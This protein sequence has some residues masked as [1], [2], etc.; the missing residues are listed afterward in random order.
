MEFSSPLAA[1]Q[2]PP[3]PFGFGRDITNVPRPRHNPFG[4]PNFNFRDLSMKKHSSDYFTLKTGVRGSSPTASLAADLSQNFHIDQSPQLP[5]PRRSLFT[6]GLFTAE[7]NREGATTPPIKPSWEGVTTPPI[8]SSSPGYAGDSMDISPLPHK[9][10]FSFIQDIQVQSPTPEPSPDED[11]ISSCE[12]TA[13]NFLQ[14]PPVRPLE[15]KRSA[16]LRPAFARSRPASTTNVPNN[17]PQE[18][19]PPF[20]FGAGGNGLTTSISTSSLD[21]CFKA[22]PPQE[23]NPFDSSIDCPP[24]PRHLFAGASILARGNGSP[25]NIQVKRSV[26]S[27]PRPRKQF[28][29]SLSMFEHPEDVMKQ[30]KQYVPSG[31]QSIMD[32]DEVPCLKLPHFI[33]DGDRPEHGSLPRITHDTMINVLDGKYNDQFEKTLIVDC[34]FEYE[35][36]GGHIQ[37]ALN[38]NDKEKLA[39][40]LFTNVQ[41]N[42]LVIFHCE[43]SNHRAPLMASF[44]RKQDRA[45]NASQYPKLSYPE[46]Y[47]L[48]GGYSAFFSNHRSR[49][50]PQ[51]YVLM[52][53]A[54]HESACERGL[55][56]L[57]GRGKLS[58]AQT[59]AFGQ[60]CQME[61]SPSRSASDACMMLDG[62]PG[63][64]FAR[65]MA[66]Y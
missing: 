23:K 26:T 2:P 53:D 64:M 15:R 34:R 16:Y 30:E 47:I 29:R 28:R 46:V 60:S 10:P 59:F 22:S 5:T 48:D 55:G 45:V 49:C 3:R 41:P 44:I 63:R 9:P 11:M 65:R 31:L 58:R 43:Y 39:K 50:Y 25:I 52:D 20:K 24:R 42:T 37:G 8:P 14:A 57:K 36:D 54:A 27:M 35:Y 18:Q 19:L 12:V 56:R 62:T 51:N 40:D 7:I 38:Y 6:S 4:K 66:S 32:V 21:E 1:M 13:S 61:D 17:K 33:P